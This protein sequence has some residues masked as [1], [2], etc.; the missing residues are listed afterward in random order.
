M[1]LLRNNNKLRQSILLLFNCCLVFSIPFETIYSNVALIISTLGLFLFSDKNH[2][3]LLLRNKAYLFL[4]SNCLVFLLG[5]IYID[6]SFFVVYEARIG[7]T[8]LLLLLPVLIFTLTELKNEEVENNILLSLV[9]SVLFG[10]FLI[11]ILAIIRNPNNQF[12][13]NYGD[14]TKY[15][16]GI[17]PAYFSLFCAMAFFIVLEKFINHIE[18]KVKILCFLILMILFGAILI[19]NARTPI[20]AFFVCLLIYFILKI[21]SLKLVLMIFIGLSSVIITLYL[22]FS[23]SQINLFKERLFNN[24]Y[25]SFLLRTEI[26]NCSWSVFK[27]FGSPWFGVGSGNVQPLLN[28]CYKQ[29][30]LTRPYFLNYN[31]H[32]EH[33]LVLVRNGLVGFFFWINMFVYGLYISVKR[34]NVLGIL[35]LLLFFIS[36]MTEVYLQR[37]WGVLFFG[38]FY[39]YFIVN[40]EFRYKESR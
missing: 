1:I 40:G 5:L 15:I 4:V 38:I 34:K 31:V 12:I 23:Q 32:N 20:V 27:N 8:I 14:L 2:L 36:C 25:F 7:K 29:N 6:M 10:L 37:I 26:W 18:L 30:F 9:Y 21:K 33:F 11:F 28:E 39:S 16:G 24:L 22:T 13:F 3:I 35:F 19:I 17:H